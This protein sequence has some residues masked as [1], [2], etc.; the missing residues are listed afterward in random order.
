MK[1]K[2]GFL[3]RSSA[4]NQFSCVS[5]ERTKIRVEVGESPI[6]GASK[7]VVEVNELAAFVVERAEGCGLELGLE[8]SVTHLAWNVAHIVVMIAEA[9][10]YGHLELVSNCL[11]HYRAESCVRSR[12]RSLAKDSCGNNR[13]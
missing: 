12:S 10:V 13:R 2:V 9:K 5:P 8:K 6:L 11:S 3:C 4:S 1:T 7:K